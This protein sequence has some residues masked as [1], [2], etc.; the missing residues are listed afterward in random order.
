MTVAVALRLL[1]HMR[2]LHNCCSVHL[3]PLLPGLQGDRTGRLL[4]YDPSTQ[5][6]SFVAGGFF[7]SNGV[8]LAKDESYL[9][10]VETCTL[11]VHRIWL[12]G[13]QV[14]CYSLLFSP[15]QSV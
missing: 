6:T 3:T 10:V 13:P 8:A 4:K 9:L 2:T 15:M 7:Y 14:S 5:Q 11:T 1:L 12:K